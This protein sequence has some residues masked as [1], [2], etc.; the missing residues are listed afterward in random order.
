MQAMCSKNEYSGAVTG[1]AGR[2]TVSPNCL[3]SPLKGEAQWKNH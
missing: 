3:L 2:R 1:A